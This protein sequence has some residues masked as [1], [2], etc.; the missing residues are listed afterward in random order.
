MGIS[1]T[2]KRGESCKTPQAGFGQCCK[3]GKMRAD[4]GVARRKTRSKRNGI[5]HQPAIMP[6]KQACE[7]Y[8]SI[9]RF[10]GDDGYRKL[11][12]NFTLHT[13]L[14]RY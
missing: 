14:R 11:F 2:Q 1:K 5:R 6:V 8:P 4:D 13:L 10:Y 9:L 12:E 3:V 7:K